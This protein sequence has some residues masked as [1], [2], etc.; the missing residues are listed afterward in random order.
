MPIVIVPIDATD[1]EMNKAFA[2]VRKKTGSTALTTP[3]KSRLT[4]EGKKLVKNKKQ[5]LKKQYAQKNTKKKG[6]PI[7]RVSAM[8]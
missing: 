5:N 2:K 3:K 8:V 4:E 6:K 1:E 7:N